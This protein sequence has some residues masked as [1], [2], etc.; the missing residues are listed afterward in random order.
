MC[1]NKSLSSSR[2]IT[3]GVPHGSVLGPLLFLININ[4]ISE[5]LQGSAR[6][7]ADNTSLSYSSR[8]LQNLQLII[9]DDLK[10]LH[11]WARRLLI[12]FNPSKTEVLLI[13]NTFID[14]DM[15]LVMDDSVLKI[16]DMH[17]HL[18]VTLSFNNKWNK[19]VELIIKS[20]SK[21]V[22]Y[23]LKA[24]YQ[25]SKEILSKLY[26]TYIRPMLEYASEVWDGCT[27][28]NAYCLEQ[29][30]LIAACIVTGLPVFAK[31]DL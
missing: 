7:F 26:C 23:L 18:G 30:Q 1:I 5:N 27:Q 19:H 22:S 31:L 10:H 28:T 3:A 21:Q 25:F 2:N 6:L 17:K 15:Q 20:G 14:F 29:V 16:V 8:N 24:K 12:T 13:S 9:Y 11:E 4:D